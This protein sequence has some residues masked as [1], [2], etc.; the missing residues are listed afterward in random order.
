MAANVTGPPDGSSGRFTGSQQRYRKIPLY[1]ARCSL[2]RQVLC[3]QQGIVAGGARQGGH[4]GDILP[5]ADAPDP[6]FW[7]HGTLLQDTDILYPHVH[8]FFF[9]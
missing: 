3:T 9:L 8:T 6:V 5:P 7:Y 2:R 4:I 1:G